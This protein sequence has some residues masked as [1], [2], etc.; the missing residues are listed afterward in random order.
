MSHGTT[1]AVRIARKDEAWF[2]VRGEREQFASMAPSGL[3]GVGK[4]LLSKRQPSGVSLGLTLSIC[5]SRPGAPWTFS[6]CAKRA[7]SC[8]YVLMAPY[9]IAKGRRFWGHG[10][11]EAEQQLA[12]VT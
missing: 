3:R 8:M 12:G 6:G 11:L 2:S 10:R 9:Q 7:E 5:R 4:G 1:G